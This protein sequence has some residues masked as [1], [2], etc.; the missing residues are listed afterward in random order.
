LQ[1]IVHIWIVLDVFVECMEPDLDGVELER[2]Q[3]CTFIAG[4][5]VFD[6][7]AYFLGD[8]TW[9]EITMQILADVL[10]GVLN[11]AM[12]RDRILRIHDLWGLPV[13]DAPTALCRAKGLAWMASC[14]T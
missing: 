2:G 10:P 6:L 13:A 8:Q 5:K 4:M 3:R 14:K 9:L 7:D 1:Q 11:N 12:G